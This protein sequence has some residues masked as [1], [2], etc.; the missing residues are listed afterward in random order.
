MPTENTLVEIGFPIGENLAIRA[1]A[2]GTEEGW[3]KLVRVELGTSPRMM[4]LR[5]IDEIPVP[6]RGDRDDLHRPRP[7]DALTEEAAV[8]ALRSAF[9][10]LH[11]YNATRAVREITRALFISAANTDPTVSQLHGDLRLAAVAEVYRH[12]VEVENITRYSSILGGVFSVTPQ[13]A[14]ELVQE[15]RAAGHL[16]PARPG[17]AGEV[18]KSR[19]KQAKA[20]KGD[21]K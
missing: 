15:A 20:N 5:S 17:A 12:L 19:K 6:E 11:V 13:R 7:L 14:K 9:Q 10:E 18:K 3:T 16:G 8:A 21:K 1:I 4:G 2:Q